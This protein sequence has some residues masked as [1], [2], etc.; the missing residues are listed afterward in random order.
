MS[1]YPGLDHHLTVT[2]GDEGDV[3]CT[4][5]CEAPEGAQC[6][7]TCD[8]GCDEFTY[9][10]HEH[11]LIDSGECMPLVYITSGDSVREFYQGPVS[12]LRDGPVILTYHGGDCYVSWRYPEPTR[13]VTRV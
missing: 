6:R 13:P 7:L 2:I 5:R 9:D 1:D 3:D 4:I 12:P 8:D 11:P 10:D